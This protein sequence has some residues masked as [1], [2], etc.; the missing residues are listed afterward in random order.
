MR[1]FR[2]LDLEKEPS[3]F[4]TDAEAVTLLHVDSGVFLDLGKGIATIFGLDELLVQCVETHYLTKAEKDQQQLVRLRCR[5]FEGLNGIAA[6]R[7]SQIGWNLLLF[8]W[9]A[10]EN[11][12]KTNKVVH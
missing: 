4:F 10:R 1:H 9:L 2:Y 3:A 12:P 5:V 6:H 7:V 8:V 11:I